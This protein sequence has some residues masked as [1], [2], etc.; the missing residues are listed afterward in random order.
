MA[1]M[2]WLS[3]QIKSIKHK[4]LEKAAAICLKPGHTW[5]NLE[6]SGGNSYVA[7]CTRCLK[8]RIGTTV[9]WPVLQTKQ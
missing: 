6:A 5:E 2:E 7:Y 8:A 3:T 4:D 1:N 9:E